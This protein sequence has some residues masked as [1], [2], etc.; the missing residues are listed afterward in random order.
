MK[1]NGKTLKCI[2]KYDALKPPLAAE[3]TVIVLGMYMFN[4]QNSIL[5]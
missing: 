2:I 3:G 1:D 4:V 5:F